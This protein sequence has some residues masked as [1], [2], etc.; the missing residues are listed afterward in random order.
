M[1]RMSQVKLD[2]NNITSKKR[3]Q[4]H[5]IIRPRM[6]KILISRF[7]L[8]QTATRK[9]RCLLSLNSNLTIEHLTKLVTAKHKHKTVSM[10]RLPPLA[11]RRP[12]NHT[13]KQVQVIMFKIT[14]TNHI[15]QAA[16]DTKGAVMSTLIRVDKDS[17]KQR[18][19]NLQALSNAVVTKEH[20]VLDKK[21]SIAILINRPVAVKQKYELYQKSR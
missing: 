10:Q 8:W 16:P 3:T 5:N 4:I 6:R 13:V 21:S 15:F 2:H 7:A 17:A 14:T 20:I 11:Q 1:H 9:N 19:A 12:H 18:V